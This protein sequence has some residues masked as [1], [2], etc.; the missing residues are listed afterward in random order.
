MP[1][2]QKWGIFSSFFAFL[3]QMEVASWLKKSVIFPERGINN[4]LLE[5]L[6]FLFFF[7]ILTFWPTDCVSRLE[8]CIEYVHI[9]YLRV[10]MVYI[11]G[12]KI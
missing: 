8:V 7:Y 10:F 5:T 3:L 1:E 6:L 2:P 12:K 11:N 4:A 9:P